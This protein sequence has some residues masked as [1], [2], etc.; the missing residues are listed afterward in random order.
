[1]KNLPEEINRP[2]QKKDI[3][4][5]LVGVISFVLIVNFLCGR[6]LKLSS[7]ELGYR[8][9]MD[10]WEMLKHLEKPVDW[11]ILGDSSGN[12]ALVPDLLNRALGVSSL[13]LCTVGDLTLMND[14]WMLRYYMERFGAPKGVLLVHSLDL[15]QRRLDEGAT[16]IIPLP[17]GFWS[18]GESQIHW[19]EA[20][21]GTIFLQKYVPLFSS[22]KRLTQK[23]LSPRSSLERPILIEKD[24]FM[25]ERMADP[26]AAVQDKESML[27]QLGEGGG[28]ISR[29]NETTLDTL[30]RLAE[31]NGFNIFLAHG[32]LIDELWQEASFRLYFKK[33]KARLEQMAESK[34]GLHL[35]LEKPIFF[36][37]EMMQSADHVIEDAAKIY[38][39]RVVRELK[40]YLSRRGNQGT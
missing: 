32:P 10:K 20:E 23:M 28:D 30:N 18:R 13:N 11:L 5:T 15:W 38:T 40:N 31:E 22:H 14:F 35:I 6:Y 39:R 3:L 29:I 37:K 8:L 16:A 19:N 9:I 4:L 2:T 1:M 12:Q 21:L 26:A 7:R 24:G 33:L 36:P 17:W 25:R 27:K 34:H